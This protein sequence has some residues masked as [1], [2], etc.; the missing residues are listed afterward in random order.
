MNCFEAR[1][2]FAS[3][4][5]RTLPTAERA[6]FIAHLRGCARCDRAFRVFAL[7]APVIHGAAE[8]AP[9][10]AIQLSDAAAGLDRS[11]H[12]TA[13]PARPSAPVGPRSA[14]PWSVAAAAVLIL[15]IGGFTAWK[16]TAAPVQDFSEALASDS[17]DLTPASYHPGGIDAAAE[18]ADP[19]PALFDSIALDSTSGGG[20]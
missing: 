12:A 7:S 8:P 20:Q 15:L 17:A 10:S 14:L 16:I 1:K 3:F 11:F 13:V 2:E 19:D 5:R 18:N 4:W 6:A 9:G